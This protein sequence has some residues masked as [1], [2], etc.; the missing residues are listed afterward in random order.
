MHPFSRFRVNPGRPGPRPVCHLH[1]ESY[2]KRWTPAIAL[3]TGL[4][5]GIYWGGPLLHG[6][7]T[8]AVPMPKELTSFRDVVKTVLPAVVSIEARAKVIKTQG[9][10]RPQAPLDQGQIPEEFRHFFEEF[11]RIP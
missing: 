8:P 10:A 11:G 6:Q 5:L 4:S 7:V 9:R 1:Q 3:V 2:M